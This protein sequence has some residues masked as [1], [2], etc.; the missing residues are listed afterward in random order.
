MSPILFDIATM[1]GLPIIGE[2]IP[3][4]HDE[5]F[6]DLDCPIYKE[7][8]SYGKYMEEHR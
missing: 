4:L 6:E 2:D 8:A 5:G 1:L 3:I 7:L